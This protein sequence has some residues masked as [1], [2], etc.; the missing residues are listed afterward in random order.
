MKKLL[1]LEEAVEI[2]QISKPTMYRLTSQKRIPHIKVGGSVRFLE[3]RLIEWLE[4]NAVEPGG[5]YERTE[6]E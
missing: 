2:L 1:T 6:T 5:T 3:S 4:S